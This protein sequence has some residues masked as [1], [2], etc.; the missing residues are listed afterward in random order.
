MFKKLNH[1]IIIALLFSSG[2]IFCQQIEDNEEMTEAE[3]EK[4]VEAYMHYADSLDNTLNY[5]HGVVLLQDG[6]ATITVPEGYKFL[7][8][9]QANYILTE[10]WGNPSD[11]ASMGLLL[12]E[13][14]NPLTVSYGIEISYSD[15]GYIDDDE[16]EDIDY[17]DLLN[18]MKKDA[19]SENEQ[20]KELGYQ[21]V[22]LVG[23]AS[24]P[25]YDSETKKL[26]W[27]KELNFEEEAANTLNYNIRVLGRNGYINLNVIGGMENLSDVK[28]NINPILNSVAF[29][30]GYA[31]SDFNPSFDKVAAYGIGG[32]IAGKVLAKAGLFAAILKFWKVIAIAVGGAFVTLRKRFFGGKNQENA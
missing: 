32:L 11:P 27:A 3:K 17:D 26:H 28:E 30:S 29:N 20:R 18:E 21:S 13:A 9:E 8:K 4:Y 5:Q 12:K 31:Y 19:I 10:I 16:A 2:N 6:I 15:E 1:F 24:P 25:F 7:D 22:E 14:E 23:W